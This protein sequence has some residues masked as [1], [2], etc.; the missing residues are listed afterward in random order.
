MTYFILLSSLRY[1]YQ[2]YKPGRVT[3]G[4]MEQQQLSARGLQPAGLFMLHTRQLTDEELTG[5]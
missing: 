5:I 3:L 2:N 4:H 1:S